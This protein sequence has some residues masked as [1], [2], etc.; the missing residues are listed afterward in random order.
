MGITLSHIRRAPV[1]CNEC[2]WSSA[3]HKQDS[4]FATL[5]VAAYK[6]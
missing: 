2:E 1:F 3:D 6:K 4:D 5:T